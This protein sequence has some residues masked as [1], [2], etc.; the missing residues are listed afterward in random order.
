MH[1]LGE[2]T[3]D[4]RNLQGQQQSGLRRNAR[5]PHSQLR[6]VIVQGRTHQSWRHIEVSTLT[7]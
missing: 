4:R 5:R 1:T 7:V 3:F 6:V 2:W